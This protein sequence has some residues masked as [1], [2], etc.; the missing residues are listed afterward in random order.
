[1]ATGYGAEFHM[2]RRYP[3]F[4]PLERRLERRRGYRSLGNASIRQLS[5][6]FLGRALSN[7]NACRMLIQLERVSNAELAQQ[8]F[9]SN[10]ELI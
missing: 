1:M 5:C 2:G 9:I 10:V 6:S 8:C 7:L 3:G 4:W